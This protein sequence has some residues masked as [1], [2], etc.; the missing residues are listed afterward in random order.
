MHKIQHVS[1]RAHRFLTNLLLVDSPR[2]VRE[3]ADCQIRVAKPLCAPRNVLEFV[4]DSLLVLS[5][6]RPCESERGGVF[7]RLQCRVAL[8]I[9]IRK[10]RQDRAKNFLKTQVSQ[11]TQDS[12]LN[13]RVIPYEINELCNGKL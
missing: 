13:S 7:H 12:T 5:E 6:N 8:G 11:A 2:D 3:R 1:R 4:R 9:R 10:D